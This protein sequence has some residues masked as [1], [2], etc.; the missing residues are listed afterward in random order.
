MSKKFKLE[1]P[2]SELIHLSPFSW[3]RLIQEALPCPPAEF[4]AFWELHPAS[5][6]TIKLYGKVIPIPRFQKLYGATTIMYSNITLVGDPDLPLIVGRCIE[7]AQEHFPIFNWNAALVNWYPDGAS[8]VSA[9]SDDERDLAVGAPILSFSLGAVRTFR[10]REK[11]ANTIVRDLPTIHASLMVMGGS[12]Q[13][14]F[15]HEI[16]KTAKP[17][18]R[19]IN[20][21]V[22]SVTE[23]V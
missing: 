2:S 23:R 1:S 6:D 7:Y 14:E 15:K 22:R 20:I 11:E 16:T 13:R 19:R 9:H 18:G 5:R 21:T 12:M 10:I 8:Y 3:V 17:M 4:D